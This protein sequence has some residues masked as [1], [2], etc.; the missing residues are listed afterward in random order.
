MENNLTPKQALENLYE[1]ASPYNKPDLYSANNNYQI[2]EQALTDYEK[3]K[4]ILEVL[5]EKRVDIDLVNSTDSV[6]F[7]NYKVFRWQKLTENEFNLIKEWL[8]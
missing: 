1:L 5:K 6:D 8:R 2:I 7:Y 4:Q 3:Q